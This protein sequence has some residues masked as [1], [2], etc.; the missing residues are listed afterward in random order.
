MLIITLIKIIKCTFLLFFLFNYEGL[1]KIMTDKKLA[2]KKK[3][4]FTWL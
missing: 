2:V 1:K 3:N 4:E